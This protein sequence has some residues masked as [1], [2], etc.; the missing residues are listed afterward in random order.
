MGAFL[1]S[2]LLLGGTPVFAQ[3]LPGQPRARDRWEA[4]K[5]RFRAL[6][7]ER[8]NETLT[9]WQEAWAADDAAELA[10]FYSEQS[11]L[12][13]PDL[14]LSGRDEIEVYFQEAL[15]TL[16]PLSFSL[17]EFEAGGTM[18]LVLATFLYRTGTNPT[19]QEDV[20]GNCITVLIEEGGRWKIR[21]QVFRRDPGV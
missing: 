13:L 14:T 1:G 3:D 20:A 12:F 8:V 5:A 10:E 7:L 6:M 17:N 19:S 9:P 16:G 2:L 18:N 21:S 4:E 15:P 11:V